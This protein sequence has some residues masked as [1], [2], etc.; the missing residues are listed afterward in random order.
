MAD[1][2][3]NM[4]DRI[5]QSAWWMVVMGMVL[6]TGTMAMVFGARGIFE[7]IAARWTT[8]AISEAAAIIAA[9]A[10]LQLCRLRNDLL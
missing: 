7:L 10:T 4:T 2:L 8:G 9:L 6:A 5:V 1:L 3:D